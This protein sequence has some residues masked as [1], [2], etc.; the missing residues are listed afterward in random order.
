M[1]L[2][3]ENLSL[4]KHAQLINVVSWVLWYIKSMVF[5]LLVKQFVQLATESITAGPLSGESTDDQRLQ[6]QKT[7]DSVSDSTS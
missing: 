4:Q 5:Q 6:S 1:P 2:F 7:N 3:H